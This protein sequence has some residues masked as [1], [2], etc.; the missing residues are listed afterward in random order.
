MDQ[1]NTP[2]GQIVELRQVFHETGVRLLRVI[3]REGGKYTS[4]DLD[5][6]SAHTWGHAM[7]AWAEQQ[8]GD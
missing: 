7:S 1:I 5:P 8:R 4:L 3:I 6:R 2:F